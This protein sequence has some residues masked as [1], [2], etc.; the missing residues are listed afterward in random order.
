MPKQN[1]FE[2]IR[3]IFQAAFHAFK[4]SF[5]QNGALLPNLRETS[6]RQLNGRTLK[7]MQ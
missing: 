4:T 6:R 5:L 3:T 2:R 7:R 1:L